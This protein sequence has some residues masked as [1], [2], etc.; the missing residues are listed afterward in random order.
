[1]DNELI[2]IIFCNDMET[3]HI[4]IKRIREI[5]VRF[6]IEPFIGI[7]INLVKSVE[8][9]ESENSVTQSA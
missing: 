6:N 9:S 1:M 5:F 7:V 4:Q 3:G 8:C 2:S